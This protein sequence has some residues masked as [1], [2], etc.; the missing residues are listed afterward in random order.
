MAHST[1]IVKYISPVKMLRFLI[2]CKICH[3]PGGPHVTA[4]IWPSTYMFD[5]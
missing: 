1:H 5:N 3:Y 2:I 4:A